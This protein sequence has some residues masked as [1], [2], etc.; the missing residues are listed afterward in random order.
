[1]YGRQA[2]R[3]SGIRFVMFEAIFAMRC[4]LSLKEDGSTTVQYHYC[5]AVVPRGKKLQQ[6]SVRRRRFL[7][8]CRG[9]NVYVLLKKIH[10][11]ISCHTFYMP[12]PSQQM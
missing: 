5:I 7:F 2:M 1:M 4:W 6:K 3:I 10:L 8:C 11:E 12:N 9:Y